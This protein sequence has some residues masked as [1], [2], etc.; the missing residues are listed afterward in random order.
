MSTILVNLFLPWCV[1]AE[2][3]LLL[4]PRHLELV[5]SKT[6]YLEPCKGIYRFAHFA[7]CGMQYPM[8][9]LAFRCCSSTN[10]RIWEWSLHVPWT[11]NNK[12]LLYVVAFVG[13]FH[14]YLR[15]AERKYI[16]CVQASFKKIEDLYPPQLHWPQPQVISMI[17]LFSGL[18]YDSALGRFADEEGESDDQIYLEITECDVT[19][20]ASL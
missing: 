12:L 15:S 13:T 5:R 20:S 6:G 17:V 14:S 9:L 18:I 1:A 19:E 16:C 3:R 2:A 11:V 8:T 7:E 4:F 10:I